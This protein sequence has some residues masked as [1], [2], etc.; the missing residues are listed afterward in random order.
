MLKEAENAL[1][2]FQRC[3]PLGGGT[4]EEREK[5]QVAWQPPSRDTIKINWDAA[6]D[7]RN[8]SMG[9][10]IIARD[11]RGGFLAAFS[12]HLSYD[13]SPVIAEALAAVHAVIFCL[14]QGYTRVLFEGDSVQIV[15]EVNSS[16][17][18]QSLYRHFIEDIK[19]GIRSL[20]HA[21][22]IHVKREANEAAHTL[23][24][25]A[26]SHVID[27][28]RWTTIPPCICGIVRREEV[29]PSS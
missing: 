14:E 7:S 16:N 29:L 21:S 5:E 18:C 20:E 2:D 8:K 26:R 6:L 4:G 25:E 24:V 27:I 12:Q 17:P 28:S 22:F 19:E 23:A 1:A 9:L 15:N 11:C 10:G 13:V 3:S